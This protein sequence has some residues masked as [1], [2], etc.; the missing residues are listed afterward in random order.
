MRL[1]R[2][3]AVVLFVLVACGP[4]GM[5]ELLVEVSNTALLGSGGMARVTVTA[6][7]EDGK[8]GTGTVHVVA[9]A[10]SLKDG[11][12][13]ELDAYGR[14]SIDF[15]CDPAVEA[16][17]NSSFNI[18]ATWGRGSKGEVAGQKR[19]GGPMGGG[20][21][22]SGAG[23]GG[24]AGGS[25]GS[26]GSGGGAPGLCEWATPACVESP[27]YLRLE[28]VDGNFSPIKGW[29][30]SLGD[31]RS[32]FVWTTLLTHSDET[33]ED[34]RCSA[35]L[36][37]FDRLGYDDTPPIDPANIAFLGG[38]L[39]QRVRITMGVAATETY[40]RESNYMLGKANPPVPEQ[41]T[42]SNS[43]CGTATVTE[44]NICRL[45]ASGTTMSEMLLTFRTLCVG[46]NFYVQG[47]MHVTK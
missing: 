24:T 14:A 47:C 43:A 5:A 37:D 42:F 4:M 40:F 21:A 25:G 13:L 29:G 26:G 20:G 1:H 27:N 33:C 15:T 38:G 34:G 3:V 39:Q 22:G 8:I 12:D 45:R 7:D 6:T 35:F 32:E 31:L 11:V 28:T 41:P 17:C 10:G 36:F 16:A 46:K 30:P 9:A 23:N 19:V 18:D 2:L 44:F